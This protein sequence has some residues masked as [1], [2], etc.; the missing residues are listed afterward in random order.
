MVNWGLGSTCVAS[1]G[2]GTRIRCG[3]SKVPWNY[4]SRWNDEVRHVHMRWGTPMMDMDRD[5]S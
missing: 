1:V 2:L 3:S 5:H 4:G